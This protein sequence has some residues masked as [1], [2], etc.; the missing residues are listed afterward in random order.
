MKKFVLIFLF[1][2]ILIL[3]QNTYDWEFGAPDGNFKQGAA[4]CRWSLNSGASCLWDEPAFGTWRFSNNTHTSMTN[5]HGNFSLHRIEF[6][7]S[8]STSRTIGDGGNGYSFRFYDFGTNNPEIINN[9]SATHTF[10]HKIEGDGDIADPLVINANAGDL[11][12][13]GDINNQ[14]SWIDVYAS[15]GKTVSISGVISGSAGL[16]NY[17]AGNLVLSGS[18]TFTGGITVSAGKLTVASGGTLGATSSNVTVKNGATLDIQDDVT[19]N[20]LT[21]ET[22]ATVTISSGKILTVNGDL[23]LT[24]TLNLNGGILSFGTSG[25][26]STGS[27]SN[28]IIVDAT[29]GGTVRKEFNAIGNWTFHIG[30]NSGTTEYSPISVDFQTGTSFSSAYVYATVVDAKH[31][32][33]SSTTHYISR[34]WTLSQSGIS[35]M[36]C[37]IKAVYLDPDDVTGSESSMTCGKYSAGSWTPGSINSSTN[38]LIFSGATTFSDITGG[39]PASL[40][41]SLINF[42]A[43]LNPQNHTE[44]SWSTA[45]ELNASHFNVHRSDNGIEKQAL[46]VV[47]AQGNSNEVVEYNFVDAQPVN[48][49]AF[50]FLEQVDFDGKTEW[51]GPVKVSNAVNNQAD[52]VFGVNNDIVITLN[53]SLEM[54]RLEAS[55]FDMQGQLIKSTEFKGDQMSSDLNIKVADLPSGMYMLYLQSDNMEQAIKLVK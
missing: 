17:S 45:S 36:D 19:I 51:F 25:S 38:T 2:P 53:G 30:E 40:P 5:N 43:F 18:N 37:D 14:G 12:F 52:A 39:E 4:G 15:S 54:D 8:G 46:G 44:L 26:F 33:N 22:G 47:T 42:S 23:D 29:N 28:Y 10:N 6:N 24:G 20:N 32:N 11:T 21:I 48:G 27:S 31:P 3:A 9:S 34:Y 35:N 49:Q 50:Y 7:S 41:V 1:S 13:N 16:H 55:L